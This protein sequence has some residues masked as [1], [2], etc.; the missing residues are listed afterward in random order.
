MCRKETYW[1]TSLGILAILALLLAPG[2]AS[3]RLLVWEDDPGG[4]MGP[5][6]PEGGNRRNPF[7][8]CDP[9]TGQDMVDTDKPDTGD[10]DVDPT[11]IKVITILGDTWLFPTPV[12]VFE[13][14]SRP[15]V[16]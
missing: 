1:K 7:V 8:P 2:L 6:D 9:F 12:S 11:R 13:L 16:R 3:A 5:G 4:F 10:V 14:M 15:L